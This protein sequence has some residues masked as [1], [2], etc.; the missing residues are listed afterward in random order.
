MEPPETILSRNSRSCNSSCS[1]EV[2]GYAAGQARAERTRGEPMFGRFQAGLA[3]LTLSHPFSLIPLGPQIPQLP[4]TTLPISTLYLTFCLISGLS[5]EYF[6]EFFFGDFLETYSSN[7]LSRSREFKGRQRTTTRTLSSDLSAVSF[8]RLD[9][10]CE[11]QTKQVVGLQKDVSSRRH[12][13][14]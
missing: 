13:S 10:G 1:P 11:A 2:A 9:F 14:P 6:L 5:Y 8:D 3:Q 12:D 4:L 7:L